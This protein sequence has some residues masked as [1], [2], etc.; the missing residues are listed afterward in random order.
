MDMDVNEL[1][2]MYKNMGREFAEV[3]LLHKFAIDKINTMLTI[4]NEDFY[5]LNNRNPIE[6]IK[7]RVKSPEKLLEKLERKG[8]ELTRENTME[9]INDI[10]GVRIVC[11]FVYEIY[12]ILDL[13]KT[14]KELT[15]TDVKDY[16][17]NPK[18]NGYRSLHLIVSTP[19]YLSNRVEDVK[20]EVQIR[21]ISMDFWASL[22]HKMNYKNGKDIS[23]SLQNR[24]KDCAERSFALSEEMQLIDSEIQN[25]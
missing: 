16:I 6:H 19:I 8:L 25:L 11:S 10:A 18:P 13:L 22:E 7:T 15:I 2:E 3:F 24:L 21:T 1:K 12:E 20:A 14:Q 17:K 5:M 23:F 4:V 9:H